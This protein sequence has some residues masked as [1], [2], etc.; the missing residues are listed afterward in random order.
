MS[1]RKLRWDLMRRVVLLSSVFSMMVYG[2]VVILALPTVTDNLSFHDSTAHWLISVVLLRF[3]VLTPA[4]D[5]IAARFSVRMLFMFGIATFLVGTIA[6]ALAPHFVI[7]LLAR[8]VQGF[9]TAVIMVL[10]SS[11]GSC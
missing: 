4:V 3:L 5:S 2:T 8:V 9:G 11:T 1:Q 10:A 6:A 7:I